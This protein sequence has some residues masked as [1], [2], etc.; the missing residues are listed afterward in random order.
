MKGNV[1]GVTPL[2]CDEKKSVWMLPGYL[3]MLRAVGLVP[4]ILP[5]IATEEEL[6][7][8]DQF[9]DGYLFTGG[10]DVDPALYDAV[11][12]ALC[13]SINHN[14]D[15]LEERLFRI[16]LA[17]DKPILGIC[18]GIQLI[19]VLLGGT[20][21]QDLDSEHP[22]SVEHH[23]LPPYN[24]TVHRVTL[25]PGILSSLI[26][27]RHAMSK[28]GLETKKAEKSR[29]NIKKAQFYV[30]FHAKPGDKLQKGA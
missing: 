10:H 23:M 3:D 20:L 19:N 15:H 5:D 28:K 22:S 27:E 4:V 9:C 13:G 25:E 1:I 29:E 12:S 11:P 2:Y 30:E 16:A 8:L 17:S 6:H 21:Y 14:R 26:V 18:R 24:R 7:R